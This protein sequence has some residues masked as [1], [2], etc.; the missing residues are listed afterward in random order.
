MTAVPIDVEWTRRA[1]RP[2]AEPQVRQD[3]PRWIRN[4]ANLNLVGKACQLWEYLN[5]SQ[6]STADKILVV[7]ALLYLISPI[8]AIPDIIPVVGWLDDIGVATGVLAYL[9]SKIDH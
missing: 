6:S 9:N 5:S 1:Q 7:A 4:V 3:F 8:D 2:D